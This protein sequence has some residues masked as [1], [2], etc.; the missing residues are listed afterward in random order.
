MLKLAVVAIGTRSKLILWP[1]RA[2]TH[3]SC[4]VFV[5]VFGELAS[6]WFSVFGK[7]VCVFR[8]SNHHRF[9]L[10]RVSCCWSLM[11]FVVRG[12]SFLFELAMTKLELVRHAV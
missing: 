10:E 4:I 11:L 1:S 8:V 6:F 2:S 12:A 9:A 3:E 5:C 7:G